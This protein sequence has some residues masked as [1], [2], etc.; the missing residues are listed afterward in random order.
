MINEKRI[1]FVDGKYLD[2]LTNNLIDVKFGLSLAS[3]EKRAANH[4]FTEIAQFYTIVNDGLILTRHAFSGLERPLYCNDSSNGDKEKLVY[5]RKPT[6]DYEWSGG[7]DGKPIRKDAPKGNVFAVFI[8]PN[9]DQDTYPNI[10]GWIEHW[11]WIE[12]DQ[13]LSEAPINWVDRFNKKIWTQE[14][15]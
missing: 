4:L 6:K 9:L 14:K 5:T 3:L 8:S 13:G 7:R 12:E 10:K 2:K 15:K 1:F 11:T